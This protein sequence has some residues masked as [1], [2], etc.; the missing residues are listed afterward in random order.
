M[1]PQ[2]DAT[3]RRHAATGARRSHF[4]KGIGIR[5]PSCTR[6][7][8]VR[9]GQFSCNPLL[10]KE[11]TVLSPHTWSWMMVNRRIAGHARLQLPL[12][13]LQGKAQELGGPVEGDPFLRECPPDEP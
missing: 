11:S 6:L 1:E 9:L 4:K 5:D 7:V 13:V 8:K 3:V 10:S 12:N 2:F